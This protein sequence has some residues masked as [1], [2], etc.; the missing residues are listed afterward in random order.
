MFK[1]AGM[2]FIDEVCT[3]D[4]SALELRVTAKPENSQISIVSGRKTS[5]SELFAM[6]YG[7]GSGKSLFFG[8]LI[9]EMFNKTYSGAVGTGY[10]AGV[11]DTVATALSQVSGTRMSSEV[12]EDPLFA[13]ME[14]HNNR[15]KAGKAAL[16]TLFKAEALPVYHNRSTGPAKTKDW[17]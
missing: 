10:V 13:A 1:G 14:R 9:H 16:K 8:N 4:L 17:E 12:D 15:I 3:F 2:S 11:H 7:R 5:K 6:A